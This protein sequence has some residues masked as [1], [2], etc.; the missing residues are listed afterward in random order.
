MFD[1][2]CG[3]NLDK[4]IKDERKCESSYSFGYTHSGSFDA[5]FDAYHDY[6][7]SQQWN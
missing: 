4:I 5:I 1:Y 7:N 2:W 6:R 3:Y